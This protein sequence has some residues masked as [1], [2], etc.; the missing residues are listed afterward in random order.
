MKRKQFGAFGFVYVLSST[1]GAG[2]RLGDDV[3][4]GKVKD[5]ESPVLH[6]P[7]TSPEA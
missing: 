1:R 4:G 5:P 6:Q 7:P 2:T 3:V